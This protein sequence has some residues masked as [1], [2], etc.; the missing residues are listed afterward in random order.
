M[1]APFLLEN[2]RFMDNYN[3]IISKDKLF[4]RGIMIS[5]YR[6]TN[7]TYD[8]QIKIL[9]RT[10]NAQFVNYDDRDCIYLYAI[11]HNQ[12]IGA[13]I[14]RHA[15]DWATI[16]NIYYQ[17]NQVLDDLIQKAWQ[18][19]QE[20]AVGIKF[21]TQVL[22]QFNDFVSAGFKQVNQI[23]YDDEFIYYYADLTKLKEKSI[24]ND[25]LLCH[26]PIEVYQ[27]ILDQHVYN[28]KKKH[29]INDDVIGRFDMAALDEEK[30]IGGIQC[31]HYE[32][33]L[34]I[35]RLVVDTNYK[36]RAIGSHLINEAIQYAIKNN[37]KFIEL[38]TVEFQARPFYEKFGFKV[39]HTRNNNPKGYKNYS[40]IKK[41]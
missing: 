1:K 38:G 7:Q 15:W 35:N 25:I 37:L 21:F 14:V 19:Y 41:L 10:Y 5:Y 29:Q 30:C 18:Y 24:D 13:L 3:D 27:E 2:H 11:A 39:V 9:L 40:M 20:K 34:Y 26:E 28:F 22:E 8:E 33:I 36:N 17:N 6:D 32:N 31:E 12:L 4:S 16:G 23:Y